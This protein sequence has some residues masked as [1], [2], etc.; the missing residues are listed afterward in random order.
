M[1]TLARAAAAAGLLA[2]TLLT[3]ACM[4][5]MATDTA[6]GPASP[7]AFIVQVAPASGMT[8]VNQFRP[9]NLETAT[10]GRG[11]MIFDGSSLYGDRVNGQNASVWLTFREVPPGDYAL[12]SLTVNTYNGMGAGQAWIC[13]GEVGSPVFTLRPGAITIVRT[14][15][16]WGGAPGIAETYAS[17]AEIMAEFNRVRAQYPN[18]QGEAV[19][20]RS[21]RR[22]YWKNNGM[23]WTSNCSTGPK[24]QLEPLTD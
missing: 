12:Y 22:V 1:R 17:D 10:W 11:S 13:L 7:T 23:G 21:D 18:L 8:A 24:F 15:P 6:F 9:V 14:E 4:T 20:A 3:S 5:P 16:Y 2:L 19:I